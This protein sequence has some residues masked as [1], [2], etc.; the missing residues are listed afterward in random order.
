METLRTTKNMIWSLQVWQGGG[1]ANTEPKDRTKSKTKEN[2]NQTNDMTNLL[3]FL[4]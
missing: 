3:N 2:S 1:H 4:N